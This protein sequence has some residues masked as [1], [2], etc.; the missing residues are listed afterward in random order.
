[1][2]WTAGD[3]TALPGSAAAPLQHLDISRENNTT[4]MEGEESRQDTRE[5]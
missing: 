4:S 5:S 1:M 3:H 2:H